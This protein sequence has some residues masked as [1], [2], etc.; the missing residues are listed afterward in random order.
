M[1]IQLSILTL[2]LSLGDCLN[3]IQAQIKAHTENGR[4]VALNSDGTWKYVDDG[5]GA[6]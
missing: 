4:E 1:E 5:G 2:C 3:P 6:I